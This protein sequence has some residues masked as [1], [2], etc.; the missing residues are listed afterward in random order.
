MISRILLF[1]ASVSFLF[2]SGCRP[3]D[4]AR[5]K[6]AAGFSAYRDGNY[7]AAEAA[8][9]EAANAPHAPV[10]TLYLLGVSRLRLGQLDPASDAFHAALKSRPK[11]GE[12]LAGLG[13]IAYHHGQFDDALRYYGQAL[14]AQLSTAEAR[15]AVHNGIALVY[16]AQKN[17]PF[18]RLNLLQ[19]QHTAPKYAPTYY[20]LGIF[21]S[22]AYKLYEEAK[23]QF[24]LFLVLAKVKDPKAEIAKNKITRLEAFI[25]RNAPKQPE[26]PVDKAA[27]DKLIEAGSESQAAHDYPRAIHSFQEAIKKDPR[28]FTAQWG[29]AMACKHR[30]KNIEALEAFRAAAKLNPTHLE[31]YANAATL[32]FLLKKY[33]VVEDALNTALAHRPHNTAMLKQTALLYSYQGRKEECRAYG[34]FYLSLLK[35]D[36]SDPAFEKWLKTL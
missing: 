14:Q 26:T 34:R 7:A 13:E 32:G 2:A 21:Y 19:A 35:K 23:D 6:F 31:C 8:F 28:S 25:R 24:K 4:T 5:R 29:L 9:R 33:D 27:F 3:G 12:S 36:E 30:G 17:L 18:C 16:S 11:H 22:D 15:A 10:E 1:T 20:N